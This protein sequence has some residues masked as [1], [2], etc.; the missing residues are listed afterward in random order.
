MPWS[1]IPEARVT[2]VGIHGIATYV[3]GDGTVA[4]GPGD[5]QHPHDMPWV[6]S[7][8]ELALIEQ[9]LSSRGYTKRAPDAELIADLTGDGRRERVAV[10][11]GTLTICG[12]GVPRR[13][14]VLLRATS[15][16]SS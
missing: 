8:P 12:D 14:G 16:G 15:A 7:E 1:A 6:P 3:D 13:H 2:R 9:V 5:A 4:T 10:W 11:D